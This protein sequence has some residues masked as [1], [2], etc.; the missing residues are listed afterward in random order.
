[1]ATASLD[2]D[3]P[4]KEGMSHSTQFVTE[5]ALV[6]AFV[7]ALTMAA[8]RSLRAR[9]VIREFGYGRGTTDIVSV[10]DDGEVVAFEAKLTRWRD[11]LAQ[12]YRNTCFAHRSFVVL[13]SLV[14]AKVSRFAAEFERRGV[15]LCAVQDGRL[16]VM[17]PAIRR[18]PVQPWLSEQA[19][20]AAT[21]R[22]ACCDN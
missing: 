15:G 4:I 14:A 20:A 12:A 18:D 19:V 5:E 6:L 2:E 17:Q 11:A 13:P 10:G 22:S 8:P 1:M 21:S 3:C 9:S 16:V 7:E